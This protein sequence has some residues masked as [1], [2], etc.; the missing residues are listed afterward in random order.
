M[1]G[2]GLV[3]KGQPWQVVEVGGNKKFGGEG[4]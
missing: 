3:G 1:L 2:K 4:K